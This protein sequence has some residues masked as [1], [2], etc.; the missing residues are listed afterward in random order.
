M[1]ASIALTGSFIGFTLVMALGYARITGRVLGTLAWL[2]LTGGLA[3]AGGFDHFELPPRM[4]LFFG[5]TLVIATVLAWRSDSAGLPLRFLVGFQAFR[6]GV[7]LLIHRAVSEGVAPPQMTW[8]GMNLD[9]LTGVTALLLFPFADRLPR[10]ALHAWNLLGWGLLVT[11]VVVAI[12]SMPTPLQRIEPDNTWVAVFPF[13]W[14]PTVHVV[15]AWSGHV[16]LLRR[17]TSSAATAPTSPPSARRR[18]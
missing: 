2:A 5:P 10:L 12:L 4:L 14:L 1:E 18:G 16:L 3:A 9:I 13:I 7:E 11:V 8:S 6:I 15:L 17:L